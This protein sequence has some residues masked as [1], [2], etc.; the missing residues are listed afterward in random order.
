[1]AD[2]AVPTIALVGECMVELAKA[3]AGTLRAGFGG[4][5]LNTAIYLKRMAGDAA[6][7][8]FGTILGEDPFADEMLSAWQAEGLAC[9]AV[10]RMT[11]RTTGLYLIDTD[12]QG[13]RSFHYWRGEAPAREL[14]RPEWS[15][16]LER[17]LASDWIYFSGITLAILPETHRAE[18]LDRIGTAA[19]RGARIAF[20]GNYRDRLWTDT[21]TAAHWYERAWRSCSLALAGLDDEKAVFGDVDAN[22]TMARL[23]KF[24]VQ[25][26][27][28]KRAD[29]PVLIRAADREDS[30]LPPP[31]RR[32]VDT[33]AAGDSF[34][35]GYLA[36]R[37][38]GKD[39]SAS[40]R[41]ACALASE[42][43]AHSGA[44][45][46]EAVTVHVRTFLDS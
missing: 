25:E 37:M 35:G 46:P 6:T 29:A 14:M 19:D 3:G 13:D 23:R 36:A 41:I 15:W 20:D 27:V 28:L 11:G 39:P 8:R 17:A 40:A 5:V 12:E 26:I 44:I 30:I 21:G 18:F 42:V 45:V 31:P 24:G 10:G 16:I 33:T 34:N 32:T 4:D 43:I 38:L 2:S 9:D 1:M 22:A 7:V